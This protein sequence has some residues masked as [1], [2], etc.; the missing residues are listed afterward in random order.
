MPKGKKKTAELVK[1]QESAIPPL[2]QSTSDV[3]ACPRFYSEVFIKGNKPP[4]GLEAARGTEI[5][6]AMAS[7]LSHCARK[8][9]GMDLDAFEIFSLGAGPQ[10][11]KI[12]MG[13]RDGFVVD[14]DHLFAT[15]LSMA[16]DENL[17]PTDVAT[18]LQGITVDSGLPSAY[19]GTLDGVYI[20]RQENKVMVDDFKSHARAFEPSETMQAKMYSLFI[21][22]IFS[23]VETVVFRLTFVRYKN[24]TRSVEYKRE[25]LPK[26][27]EEIK[28]ARERQKTIHVKYDAGDEIEAI[29]GSQ[30]VYC[31]LLSNRQ[32]PISEWN[33]QMQFEPVDR[34]KFMLWYSAFSKVNNKTLRDYV[35]GTGRKVVLKDYN[36][37][38]YVFG[39]VESESKVYPLFKAT[40]N[41]IEMDNQGRPVMPIVELLTD[42]AY[43]TPD[44]TEWM[45]KLVISATKL[46]SALGAKKR[47]VI[48]QA[49]SDTADKVTKAPLKVSKPLDVF[50]D[51]DEEQDENEWSDDGDEF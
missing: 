5:H 1:I 8:S 43:A 32:C 30:C 51:E 19:Q 21:F 25:E 39:P 23:W 27:I 9:I 4:G 3:M 42:Y 26:L 14:H 24:M 29:S 48:D 35:N 49:V 34:L 17:Q 38:A 22:Q 36:G 45:G 33:P 10:A 46:N 7:Y 15:E 18:E 40:P 28:A 31:P 2:R 6:E 12:L 11:Y 20:F 47:A 44:D 37:K 41:G 16:L 50:E 13:L